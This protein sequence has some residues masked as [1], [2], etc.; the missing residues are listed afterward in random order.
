M[1]V[2]TQVYPHNCSYSLYF[3]FLALIT[4]APGAAHVCGDCEEGYAYAGTSSGTKICKR[5]NPCEE[6]KQ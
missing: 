4:V 1:A 2:F 6:G 3:Y 5:S